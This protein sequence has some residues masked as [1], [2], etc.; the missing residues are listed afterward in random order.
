D[1]LSAQAN[2]PMSRALEQVVLEQGPDVVKNVW[3]TSR[4]QTVAPVIYRNAIQLKATSIATNVVTLFDNYG[5][6]FARTHQLPRCP[7]TSWTSPKNRHSCA[8]HDVCPMNN[9]VRVSYSETRFPCSDNKGNE[10]FCACTV[11][12]I[13]G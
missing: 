4:M 8:Y 7:H 5:I 11:R 1:P 2:A 10:T 13:A 3:L 9:G 6:R 12:F